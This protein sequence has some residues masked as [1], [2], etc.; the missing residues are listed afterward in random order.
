MVMREWRRDVSSIG[1]WTKNIIEKPEAL[2]VNYFSAR[3][4]VLLLV[5]AISLLVL[6]LLLPPLPPPPA[7]LLLVPVLIMSV[8]ILLAFSPAHMPNVIVNSV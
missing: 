8:L 4:V 7:L 5:L 3:S 1:C 2:M 6:P